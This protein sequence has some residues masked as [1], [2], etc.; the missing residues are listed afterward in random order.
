MA[1][2]RSG[3]DEAFRVIYDRY[4]K[5]LAGYARQMLPRG[6]DAQDALQ[7]VF[8]RAYRGLRHD[9]RELAIRPWLFRI[10]HNCCIDELR[11]TVPV[12]T[13]E[14]STRPSQLDDPAAQLDAREALQR[15]IQDIQRLPEQQRSA[16]LLRE[17]SGISYEEVAAALETTVPAVKSLLVRARMGLVRAGEARDTACSE[18]REQIARAHDDGVRATPTVRRHLR[19]CPACRSYRG[20]MGVVN[21]R[22]AALLPAGPLARLV[23]LPGGSATGAGS[24][25][26]AAAL[27]ASGTASG[28][29][30]GANHVAA[31][32]AAAIASTGGVVGLQ[33]VIASSGAGPAAIHR[34]HQGPAH[35]RAAPSS[36]A[37]TATLDGSGE[38]QAGEAPPTSLSRG[39]RPGR[40]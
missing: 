11:R 22:V 19:D 27:S 17:L 5:R 26:P 18:I 8:V 28:A 21:K 25:A 7:D 33:H 35:G 32:L 34:S 4:H 1:L 6:Y 37:V 39:Q 9:D 14:V 23:G 3:H 2:F 40:D 30:L 13:D 10:A 38:S 31:L 12:P 24:T 16:L 29:A 20:Q 15:L 36:S